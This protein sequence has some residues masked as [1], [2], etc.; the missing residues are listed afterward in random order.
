VLIFQENPIV[1]LLA[2]D[3]FISMNHL[4]LQG[5]LY[6]GAQER[7]ALAT[8]KNPSKDSKGTLDV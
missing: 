4:S 8:F 1:A 5:V 7:P 3:Q 6:Q 2:E